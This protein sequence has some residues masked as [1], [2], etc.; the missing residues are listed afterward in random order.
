MGPQGPAGT[1]GVSSGLLGYWKWQL[2]ATGLPSNTEATLQTNVVAGGANVLEVAEVDRNGFNQ[3][4]RLN[5]IEVNDHII[6]SAGG[7]PP[8]QTWR[9]L[10]TGPWVD[11]GGYRSIPV[12]WPNALQPLDS[13]DITLTL[14]VAGPAG[15]E[16]A[17]GVP[18]AEGPQGPAGP[19]GSDGSPGPEGPE[20]P[21]GAPGTPGAPGAEGPKGDVGDPG[22]PGIPGET[23]PAGPSG[24][25]GADGATG[26]TG[27]EGPMGP[28]GPQGETGPIGPEGPE[29]PQGPQGVPGTATPDTTPPPVVEVRSGSES[30]AVDLQDDGTTV[31]AITAQVGFVTLPTGFGDIGEIIVQSTRFTLDDGVTPDWTRATQW[32]TIL[33]GT[34][35]D[36]HLDTPVTQPNVLPATPYV[37]RA[38]AVDFSG[39]V[40]Q[41]WSPAYPILTPEDLTGPSRVSGLIVV[42]GMNSIGL[43]WDPV[44][45]ADFARTEVE[46][47]E[48]GGNWISAQTT[49]TL[50]VVTALKNDVVYD[51]R[52]RSVDTSGNTL[53]ADDL[54]YKASDPEVGWTDIVT[55]TPTAL[56]GSALIW[57]AAIIEDVFTGMLDADWIVAGTLV[58]GEGS[59]TADAIKVVNSEGEELGTW[60]T[61]GITVKDPTNTDYVLRI[62]EASLIIYNGDVP[63]VT[64]N[65]LGIDA[66]SITFGSMR[67]GHNL[68]QN[69]SFELGKFGVT[70]PVPRTWDVAADWNAAGSR[71]GADINV[72][73]GASAL[74]MTTVV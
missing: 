45:D 12:I 51:I 10:V 56:P 6:M 29:G 9:V 26:P 43:R 1:D 70:V 47:R 8:T 21:T 48:P 62:T 19:A 13:G 71:Q 40:Q 15:E 30:F 63:V 73:T 25:P 46:F 44:G 18:G 3:T 16:G 24:P 32:H 54:T 27:P 2:A 65:P 7:D 53:G 69:S 50:M 37:W 5:L 4:Q 31:I 42:P 49:G 60:S 17:P 52:L 23:G 61:D 34:N 20:G 55:A 66:A 72:T 41:V 22:A 68:V 11:A 14:A 38:T 64:L 35:A 57:D 28:T 39:N 59:G 74:T 33:P 67:G 36:G 58:V